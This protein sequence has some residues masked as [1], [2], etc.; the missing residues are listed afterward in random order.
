M[1]AIIAFA[2]KP[3]FWNPYDPL[4]VEAFHRRM[5]CNCFCLVI[6][7]YNDIDVIAW[8]I[9]FDVYDN[10]WRGFHQQCCHHSIIHHDV[11][12]YFYKK[13]RICCCL[14]PLL[15]DGFVILFSPV[16]RWCWKQKSSILWLTLMILSKGKQHM[17][18]KWLYRTWFML[19]FVVLWITYRLAC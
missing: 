14:K 15:V 10:F 9:R 8:V 2:F 12:A 5:V 16:I 7:K 1:H 18:R 3:S 19:A 13:Y 17:E 6:S 4:Q 11:N